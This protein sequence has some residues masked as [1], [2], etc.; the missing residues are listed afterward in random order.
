MK[1]EDFQPGGVVM[2]VGCAMCALMALSS[3]AIAIG[4]RVVRW[5][6]EL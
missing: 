3:V 2:S 5:G 1:S 4:I 6:L